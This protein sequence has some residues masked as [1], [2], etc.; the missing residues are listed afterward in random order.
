M[1]TDIT[2][3]T[4]A[5]TLRIQTAAE[6][7]DFLSTA[8]TPK[9]A[10]EVEAIAAA[11]RSW[12][13]EHKRYEYYVNSTLLYIMARRRTTEL[14]LPNICLGG[15]GSN[16]YASKDDARVTLADYGFTKKQW[17]RRIKELNIS[18]D[19]LRTYFDECI[20]NGWIP[21]LNGIAKLATN[22]AGDEMNAEQRIENIMS[23]IERLLDK[24]PDARDKLVKAFWGTIGGEWEL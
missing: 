7:A 9:E 11:N 18:R 16:Q 2:Q 4:P 19:L 13:R 14:I 21:S 22:K 15:N 6:V 5:A 10:K 20:T 24:Y 12:A 1:T 23:A 3:A 8:T 17:N